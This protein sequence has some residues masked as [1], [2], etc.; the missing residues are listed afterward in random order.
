M[1]GI[2]RR[3]RS[4]ACQAKVH[5]MDDSQRLRYCK[6]M[7]ILVIIPGVLYKANSQSVNIDSHGHAQ[8][9]GSPKC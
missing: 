9:A 7:E 4:Q 3:V 2:T 1:I 6:L 8:L 5:R